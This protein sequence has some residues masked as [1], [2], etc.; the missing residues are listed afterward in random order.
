MS[1][2]KKKDNRN[3]LDCEVTDYALGDGGSFPGGAWIGLSFTSKT[4]PES[5]QAM[6]AEV[7]CELKSPDRDAH[8]TPSDVSR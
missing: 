2:I 6:R 4:F 5:S 7:S 3:G 1:E 8:C